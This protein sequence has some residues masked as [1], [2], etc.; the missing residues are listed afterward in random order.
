MNY[1]LASADLDQIAKL[2]S[3]LVLAIIMK[4]G[5]VRIRVADWHDY[6]GHIE[7][8]RRDQ[9]RRSDV[10]RGFSMIVK[11]G[12]VSGLFPYSRLNPTDPP[13]LSEEQLQAVAF[14]LPLAPAFTVY[15]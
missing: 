3:D 13:G 15:R 7:W 2:Q 10:L 6:P 5:E 8:I 1:T 4:D 11:N 12:L 9:I 14:L